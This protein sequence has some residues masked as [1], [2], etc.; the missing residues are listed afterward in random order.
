MT[1]EKA[2]KFTNY[3]SFGYHADND[4]GSW[5]SSYECSNLL[6]CSNTKI[7]IVRLKMK[8]DIMNYLYQTS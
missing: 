3:L 8:K 1:L 5:G 6:I 2:I 4:S 7:D